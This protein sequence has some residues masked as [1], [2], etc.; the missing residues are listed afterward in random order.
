MVRGAPGEER[1]FEFVFPWVF[2]LLPLPF[3]MLWLSR[4]Q[5]ME[6]AL[7]LPNINHL[8]S[9]RQS[10]VPRLWRGIVAGLAWAALLAAVAQPQVVGDAEALPVTGRDLMMALDISG[11]MD[12][13]DFSWQGQRVSRLE[14]VRAVASDFVI[15]R[16]GDRVGLILFGSQPYL[17]TPLTF[18]TKTVHYFV[19][20]AVVG[21]AGKSTAIGDAIGLAVKRLRDRPADSRVLILLTDGENTAG[22]LQPKQAAE[23]AKKME[24]RVHTIGVGREERAFFGNII[25]GSGIDE[26][27][28]REVSEITGGQFFK[29][30][31]TRELVDVYKALDKL[32]PAAAG[33]EVL[34]S[35]QP[36][37]PWAVAL[38][39]LLSLVL[40][41]PWRWRRV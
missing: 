39:L 25:R 22:A 12:N 8:P 6:G 20:D 16:K 32:E 19:Q 26:A 18:D 29:A 15:R 30:K 17:Q 7:R 4:S 36:L 1:V 23:L 34:S 13:R 31:N 27:S 35:K 11:S 2:V 5:R 14:A 9:T 24:V 3:F 10:F 40:L 41:E 33:D 21:L 38:A 28:L 37:F